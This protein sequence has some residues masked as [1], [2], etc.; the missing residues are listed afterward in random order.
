MSYSFSDGQ[1]GLSA[2]ILMNKQQ[3]GSVRVRAATIED[4][5]WLATLA[6]QL[7]EYERS[8]NQQAGELSPWA[9]S[10]DEIRKQMRRPGTRFFVAEDASPGSSGEIIGYIKAVIYGLPPD[11]RETGLRRWLL[12]QAERSA[13]RAFNF[14][15]RRPRPNVQV[16]GGYIAGT[17]VR[18]DGRRAGVGQALVS[19][20][21][22]WFRSHGIV[23]SELHVLYAN[24]SARHFWEESGYE[25]LAMGMRRK[26]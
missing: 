12:A 20:A 25:P 9:A 17:F 15:M 3:S 6:R 21:E 1:A 7:L 13:R 5:R 10:V 19:A 26:L 18:P 8:L 22:E 2:P 16:T 11:R 4:A 23:T 24:T 14:V